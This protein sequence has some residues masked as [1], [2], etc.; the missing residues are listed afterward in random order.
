ME[1]DDGLDNF[2]LQVQLVMK[3]LEQRK[4]EKSKE[5][6]GAAKGN[7]KVPQDD[8][9]VQ[10]GTLNN[11]RQVEDLLDQVRELKDVNSRLFKLVSDKDFEIRRLK[12]KIEEDQIALAGAAGFAG[13]VAATKIVELSKKNRELSAEIE[14]EKTKSKQNAKKVKELEKELQAALL[15]AP[16]GQKVETRTHSQRSEENPVVLE[17]LAAAELKVAEYRNH[18]QS[19]KQELKV[20]HKVLISEVGEEVNIQQLL[21]SPGSFRGRSQQILA[22]KTRVRDLEQ[23]LKEQ[24]QPSVQSIEG[25]SLSSVLLQRTP[26]REKNLSHIRNI[27]KEKREALERI[28]VDYEALL[29]EHE[30]V[31]KKLDASK[32]RNKYLSTEIKTLKSQISDL[33]VKSKHDD[34]L[35]DA[36]L[37]QQSQMQEM[38]RQL[39][40]Q[41]QRVQ[42][43]TETVHMVTSCSA[44][45]PPEEGDMSKQTA[46]SCTVFKHGHKQMQP[47]A[48]NNA[49]TRSPSKCPQCSADVSGLI[50][51]CDE[52]R[53]L[54]EEKDRLFELVNFLQTKD[55]EMN[56]RLQEAEQKYREERGRMVLLEQT[57]ENMNL[58]SNKGQ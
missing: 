26:P 31:K 50:N 20:A 49:K 27:R 41:Q 5:K 21:S 24:R 11:S 35:V 51:Q 39:S 3:Q 38:L 34:E 32:A 33:L 46:S 48:G 57:L 22:L 18:V 17:K 54:S 6:K 1:R 2:R 43:N 15:L 45:S 44:R 29:K 9:D 25:E 40:Q 4:H 14:Q 28:S 8:M 12:K 58:D 23:Q 10:A 16:P 19:V 56:R 7:V 47:S 36:L 53:L 30:D 37:K 13:D 55:K 52:F 42:S